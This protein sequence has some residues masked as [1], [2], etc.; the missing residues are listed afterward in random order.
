[1]FVSEFAVARTGR[2]WKDSRTQQDLIAGA[3]HSLVGEFSESCL[4]P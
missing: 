3:S 4:N 1:M 2:E